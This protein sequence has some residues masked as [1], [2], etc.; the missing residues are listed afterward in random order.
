MKLLVNDI[1][2]NWTSPQSHYFFNT[3][4]P[5]ALEFE[6][7][8]R[9]VPVLESHIYLYTSSYSKIC[10]LSK[11]ALLFSAGLANQNLKASDRDKWLI[12]LPFFHVSGISILA[13]AF[14]TGSSCFIQEGAWNPYVFKETIQKKGVTL[15]SLVPTQVYDLIQQNLSAP[16]SL[17]AVLV[18]GDHLSSSIYKKAGK[19]DWPLMICY[20][21]TETCSHIA[22]SSLSS[23]RKKRSPKMKLL[24]CIQAYPVQKDSSGYAFLKIRSQGLASAYF[25]LKQRKLYDPKE[26]GNSFVLKDFLLLRGRHLKVLSFFPDRVKILGESVDLKK[27]QAVLAKLSQGRNIKSCLMHIPDERRACRL[28]LLGSVDHFEQ[29]SYLVRQFNHRVSG[30]EKIQSLYLLP[31]FSPDYFLKLNPKLFLENLGF[32]TEIKKKN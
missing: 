21:A 9:Q 18:G 14:L 13:R 1:N 22:S 25:D 19:L 23:L 26:E 4:H 10:L 28:V 15:S 3:K 24:P 6:K 29:L 20:G 17:R 16:K 11:K 27:L 5:K 12:S 32:K 30:Y 8:A 31:Q 2:I 7:T